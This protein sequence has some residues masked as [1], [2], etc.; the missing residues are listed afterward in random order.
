[1]ILKGLKS[2]C[3]VKELKKGNIVKESNLITFKSLK[4]IN[5]QIKTILDSQR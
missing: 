1:M 3:I 2:M 5:V 4:Q